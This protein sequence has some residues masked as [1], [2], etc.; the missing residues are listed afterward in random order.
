[1]WGEKNDPYIQKALALM[2]LESKFRLLVAAKIACYLPV[3]LFVIWREAW[4]A[5][6]AKL[7]PAANEFLRQLEWINSRQSGYDP[8]LPEE[9]WLATGVIS[10]ILIPVS[11]I[12]LLMLKK[13]A[14]WVHLVSV[15]VWHLHTSIHSQVEFG[16]EYSLLHISSM[17][18]GAILFM[19]FF[20]DLFMPPEAKAAGIY[21]GKED[22]ETV[23]FGLLK[24]GV[25][26]LYENGESVEEG[27]WKVTNNKIHITTNDPEVGMVV[28]INQINADGSLTEIGEMIDGKQED[29]PKEAQFTYKQI[30]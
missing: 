2:K 25:Y 17:L 30:K 11:L 15:V 6:L 10:F 5:S 24:D 1:V 27:K 22:N 16:L 7:S 13:W 8:I 14:A 9:V 28:N 20:T 12:G 4:P 18:T 3:T 23:K 29:T 19:A 26:E 21:E